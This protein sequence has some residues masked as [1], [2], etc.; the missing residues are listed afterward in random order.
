[1][2]WRSIAVTAATVG[3]YVGLEHTWPG[4]ETVVATLGT[5]LG[6]ALAAAIV[7]DALHSNKRQRFARSNRLADL[8]LVT[9]GP[10]AAL[11]TAG[12]A[13]TAGLGMGALVI[14]AVPLVLLAQ[15]FDR[16]QRARTNLFAWI[17]AASVAPEFAGL[18]APGR[19]QRI[20]RYCRAIAD[21]VGLDD[22]TADQLE[23]AAWMERVGE[24]CLDESYV[25]GVPHTAEDIVEE[26]A[27]ILKST[28]A[29]YAAGQILWAYTNE[30]ELA[31]TTNVDRAGQILRVAIA[32]EDVTNGDID[33]AMVP[34]I[35]ARLRT[36]A[37]HQVDADICDILQQ[38]VAPDSHR[39]PWTPVQTHALLTCGCVTAV[40][41]FAYTG[42][43]MTCAEHGGQ[44]VDALALD[45]VRDRLDD[46]DALRRTT[47]MLLDGTR[48]ERLRAKELQR[49]LFTHLTGATDTTLGVIAR[50][51]YDAGLAW[52]HTIA[53]CLRDAGLAPNR[54]AAVLSA[55]G[56]AD[57]DAWE[58]MKG[59]YTPEELDHPKTPVTPGPKPSGAT[60]RRARWLHL[61]QH[62][63]V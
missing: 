11:G 63:P 59:A 32:F 10:L 31:G 28:K 44:H 29:F 47:R 58:A 19:A 53:E 24:C 49:E 1:M 42:D 20:A 51:A 27:A 8:A 22:E 55:A 23:A 14:L 50:T 16:N 13:T 60:T 61:T 34:A 15:G 3:A 41:D 26:S 25:S 17:Q 30:P 36:N 21:D 6:A 35:F 39:S 12:T 52:E 5:L 9:C 38:F 7:D 2:A 62:L 43:E 18:A 46:A 48:R 56:T 37:Y 40:D 45:Q 57:W 4:T 54:T 33:I